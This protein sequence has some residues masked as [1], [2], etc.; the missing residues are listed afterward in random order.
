MDMWTAGSDDDDPMNDDEA[1]EYAHEA[2]LRERAE[3]ET[4]G[5][6]DMDHCQRIRD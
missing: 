4:L 1:S 3:H 2:E 5:G 6:V